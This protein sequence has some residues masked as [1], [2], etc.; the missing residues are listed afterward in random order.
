MY[1]IYVTDGAAKYKIN[2]RLPEYMCVPGA[3]SQ[4]TCFL[5]KCVHIYLDL[6]KYQW[7]YK[8]VRTN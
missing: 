8:D 4:A 6:K 3:F 5:L 7:S 1:A 2:F